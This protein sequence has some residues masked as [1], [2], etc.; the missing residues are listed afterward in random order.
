MLKRWLVFKQHFVR[1]GRPRI[2]SPHLLRSSKC[3]HLLRSRQTL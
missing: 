3:D 1:F 2:Y